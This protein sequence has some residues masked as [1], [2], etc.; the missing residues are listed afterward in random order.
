MKLV[1]GKLRIVME[2]GDWKLALD[3]SNFKFPFSIT[4]F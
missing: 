2:I 1:T 4:N 3:F